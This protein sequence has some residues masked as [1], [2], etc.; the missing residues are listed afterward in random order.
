MKQISHDQQEAYTLGKDNSASAPIC[1]LHCV[2]A[3]FELMDSVGGALKVDLRDFYASLY[4]QISRLAVRPGAC[5]NNKTRFGNARNEI[6]LL[7]CG[8][9]SMLKK[10]REVPIERVAAFVKRLATLSIM[11]PGN[12]AMASLLTVRSAFVVHYMLI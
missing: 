3:A 11:T 9:E 6:E 5:D 10:N 8:V 12:S 4:T 7:L 2:I 1:A